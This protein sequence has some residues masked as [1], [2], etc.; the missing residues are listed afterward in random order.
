MTKL[1]ASGVVFELR[2]RKNCGVLKLGMSSVAV[3]DWPTERHGLMT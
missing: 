2:R 1:R 3:R